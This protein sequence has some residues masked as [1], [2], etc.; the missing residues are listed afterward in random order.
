MDFERFLEN[1]GKEYKTMIL[2]VTFI[3]PMAYADCWKLSPVFPS[4]ESIPQAI[5]S[6]AVA[7]ILLVGGVVMDLA[8]QA[9]VSSGKVTYNVSVPLLIMPTIPSSFLVIVGI[10]DSVGFFC[11][12]YAW[13][14]FV[15][16]I[17]WFIRKLLKKFR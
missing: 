13:T 15:F 16:F 5:L 14:I 17:F 12:I 9:Y 1:L 6:L 11:L 7:V 10:I 8:Y 2:A 4:L 3:F